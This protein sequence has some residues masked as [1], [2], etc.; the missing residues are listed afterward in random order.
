MTKKTETI[1]RDD[2][3]RKCNHNGWRWV[4]VSNIT[5]DVIR[6]R[7]WADGWADSCQVSVAESTFSD[8][9]DSAEK[10][11]KTVTP[12]EYA[13]ANPEWGIY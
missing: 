9:L 10:F 13:A 1:T 12:H 2:L 11:T 7:L 8:A 4:L 3:D 5:P 6:V